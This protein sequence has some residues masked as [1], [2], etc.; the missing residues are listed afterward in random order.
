MSSTPKQ[1][2][3]AEARARTLE[4]IEEIAGEQL[5]EGGIPG[6][7]LRAISRDLGMAPSAIY[8]YFE[9]SDALLTHL[10]IN[11]FNAISD[12][13]AAAVDAHGQETPR[14]RLRVLASATREF[15]I[16]NPHIFALL[17]G[18]PIPG[19]QAPQDTVAPASRV[20]EL[21]LALIVEARSR[22]PKA[23]RVEASTQLIDG[24]APLRAAMP[25]ADPDVLAV[26][27]A[28]WNQLYGLISFELFGHFV[29]AV[30]NYAE[31]FEAV[32]DMWWDSLLGKE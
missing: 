3:R 8:R 30:G 4:R 19:Y 7:S 25:D 2:I 5:R 24:I 22:G 18:T 26:G 32:M 29:N 28:A 23:P 1:G 16:D 21:M 31:Y 20:G 11:G 17:Y 13:V 6:L 15:F 10:I 14:V 12:V 9:S 27:I